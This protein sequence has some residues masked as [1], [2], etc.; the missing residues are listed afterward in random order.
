MAQKQRIRLSEAVS[1]VATIVYRQK[2]NK[3]YALNRVRR[4]IGTAV[5]NRTLSRMENKGRPELIY[6][7]FII[8]AV[9]T[10]PELRN[11]IVVPHIAKPSTGHLGLSGHRPRARLR[12]ED[13]Q[14]LWDRHRRALDELEDCIEEKEGLQ[15]QLQESESQLRVYQ[16]REDERRQKASDAGK[17]GGSGKTIW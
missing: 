4:R 1:L 12:P 7:D 15:E 17:K 9:G 11:E 2:Y 3:R 5:K 10:W 8:W 14:E 6:D 16:E 13:Y